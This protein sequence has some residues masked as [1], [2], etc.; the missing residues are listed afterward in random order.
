[1]NASHLNNISAIGAVKADEQS[2]RGVGSVFDDNNTAQ[3]RVSGGSWGVA[4][5]ARAHGRLTISV[6]VF[7]LRLDL[8]Q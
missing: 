3:M 6:F 1:M 2:P 5:A 7:R 8:I 4:N